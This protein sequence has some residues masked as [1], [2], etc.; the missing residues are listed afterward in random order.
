MLEKIKNIFSNKNKINIEYIPYN[1]KLNI[2]FF[3]KD[4]DFHFNFFGNSNIKN[5]TPITAFNSGFISLE[6]LY[7]FLYESS[8]SE[9]VLEFFKINF[10]HL[11][12]KYSLE[13]NLA[14]F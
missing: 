3:Q 10:P 13:T 14:G 1:S 4:I 8:F 9:E 12:E 6:E 11:Y 7:D 5:I 2:S